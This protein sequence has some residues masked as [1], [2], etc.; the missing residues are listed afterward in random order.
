MRMELHLR[1]LETPT[2]NV[3]KHASIQAMAD[4]EEVGTG[5]RL[6][7]LCAGGATSTP[8]PT[9]HP[10]CPLATPKVHKVHRLTD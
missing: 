10:R 1:L 4:C 9:S 5:E 2:L 6:S 7:S 3:T 8:G